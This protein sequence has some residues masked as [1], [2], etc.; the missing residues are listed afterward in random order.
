MPLNNKLI[1]T[2]KGGVKKKLA[3]DELITGVK[4][5]RMANDLVEGLKS[6]F[7]HYRLMTGFDETQNDV[8]MYIAMAQ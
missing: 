5:E 2:P 4:M 6:H 1:V 7:S 8:D 3:K